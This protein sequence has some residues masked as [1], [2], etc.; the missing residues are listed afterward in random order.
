MYEVYKPVE[1]VQVLQNL[2]SHCLV[3]LL[4]S[5]RTQLLVD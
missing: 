5:L 2:Y 4:G 1:N 3:L